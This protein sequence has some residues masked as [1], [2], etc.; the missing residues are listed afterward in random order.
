MSDSE[1]CQRC[2]EVGEDRR[3]LWMA[4]FYAM[5]E[6]PI[7]FDQCA[8][9]GRYM[10]YVGEKEVKLFEAGGPVTF[11]E[12]EHI[13]ESGISTHNFFTLR[14]CKNCR[15]DWMKQIQNWFETKPEKPESVGTGIFVR[16]RGSIREI[17]EEEW[18]ER[19]PDREPVRFINSIEG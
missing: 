16:D 17:T 4:C 12:F 18:K 10:K 2:G 1:K 7:P 5:N 8:I 15:A 11:P 13:P 3:T 19:C 6:L 9:Q 14:V